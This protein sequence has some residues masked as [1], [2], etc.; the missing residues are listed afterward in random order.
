MSPSHVSSSKIV[1]PN[2]NVRPRESP[3]SDFNS[4]AL[5]TKVPILMVSC[6]YKRYRHNP[7]GHLKF[8][9]VFN[10]NLLKVLFKPVETYRQCH[11]SQKSLLATGFSTI[12]EPAA[13]TNFEGHT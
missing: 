11:L 3:L 2:I 8:S 1:F 7:V 13:L 12:E 5:K 9:T 10:S 6:T 4:S